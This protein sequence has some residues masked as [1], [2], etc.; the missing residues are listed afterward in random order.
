MK[1]KPTIGSKPDYNDPF[2]PPKKQC[3]AYCI[4][5]NQ[6]YSSAEMKWDPIDCLW[7]CRDWPKCSGAGFGC[8]IHPLRGQEI[9]R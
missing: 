9:V 7:V 4:H 8:D 2:R 3:V 6:T 5:C 1:N